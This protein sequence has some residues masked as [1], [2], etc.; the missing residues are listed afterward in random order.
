MNISELI[1]I[2]FFITVFSPV[3][4]FIHVVLTW[5]GMFGYEAGL[6]F[7]A[8]L[9]SWIV[10]P[11]FGCATCMASIWGTLFW[12]TTGGSLSLWWVVACMA[13]SG[14]NTIASQLIYSCKD[15]DG[16]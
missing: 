9:P 1:N 8:M 14:Y 4:I 6:F 2:I 7:E 16:E 12:F 11:L 5:E 3:C 13:L 15:E 10:K